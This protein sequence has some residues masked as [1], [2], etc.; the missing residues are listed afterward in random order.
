RGRLDRRQL[1]RAAGAVPAGPDH[2][3]PGPAADRA[4]AVARRP[5]GA[6]DRARP[7]GPGAGPR[8]VTDAAGGPTPPPPPPSKSLTPPARIGGK[9]KSHGPV[10]LHHRRRGVLIGTRSR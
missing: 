3:G 4:R 10:R 5:G 7:A 6:A 1:G 2:A 8:P 9:E